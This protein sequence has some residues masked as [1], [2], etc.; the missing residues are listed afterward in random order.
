LL[1]PH[2][3]FARVSTSLKAE[4]SMQSTSS[5]LDDVARLMTT[6]IGMAQGV[7]DE[8][9]S[10]MRAQADRFVAD[11]DLVTRDEF[12]SVKAMALAAK[13]ES[14]DLRQRLERLEALLSGCQS[15]G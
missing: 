10:F 7:Q 6:G 3:Y 9:K 5:I 2:P 4:K 14:A 15:A 8:A 1:R 12:E 13:Q 11:M